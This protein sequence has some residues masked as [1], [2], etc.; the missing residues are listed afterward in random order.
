MNFK[1]IENDKSYFVVNNLNG[2]QNN[3]N[4]TCSRED[5]RS[6]LLFV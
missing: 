2:H 4:S 3:L 5:K 6:N 1:E